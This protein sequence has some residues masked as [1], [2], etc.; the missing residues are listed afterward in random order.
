MKAVIATGNPVDGFTYIGPYDS[1][2]AAENDAMMMH[3]PW[4]IINL[5]SP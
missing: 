4:W 1:P 3:S 2:Q 5:K